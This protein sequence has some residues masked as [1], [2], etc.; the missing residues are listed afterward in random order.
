MMVNV[1]APAMTQMQVTVPAGIGPGMPFI[2]NTPGGGQMEVTCP[3]DAVAGGQM[4]VNV[5]AATI[6]SVAAVAPTVLAEAEPIVMGVVMDAQLV[7]AQPV[8]APQAQEMARASMHDPNLHSTSARSTCLYPAAHGS[9]WS[10]RVD[11]ILR[12]RARRA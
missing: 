8:A 4:L 9:H 5:P 7:A 3:P 6:G 1:P 12:H 2:D 11:P 10:W